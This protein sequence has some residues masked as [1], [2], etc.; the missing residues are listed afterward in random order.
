MMAT[1]AHRRFLINELMKGVETIGP[2]YEAFGTRL[3]D[4]IVNQKMQHRGLNPEGHPVGHAVDS[5]SETG[6]V[7]AE[8]SAEEGYFDQPFSKCHWALENQPLMGASKPASG[9][10]N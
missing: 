5:V 10:G 7:A 4:Y 1:S 9:Y 8:Y 6:E 3:V 2:E